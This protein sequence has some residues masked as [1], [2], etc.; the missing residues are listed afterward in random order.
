M[1]LNYACPV[2]RIKLV[3]YDD[4]EGSPTRGTLV[5]AFLGPDNHV[6]AVIPPEVWNGMKGMSAP[7]A[8]V[9]NCATHTHDPSRTEPARP[10]RDR[11][12]V[13]L[14]TH[15]TSR[16][17]C[18]TSVRAASRTCR[19]GQPRALGDVDQRVLA[20]REVQH[21]EQREL[22]HARAAAGADRPVEAAPTELRLALRA[23]VHVGRVRL[24]HVE[25]GQVGVEASAQ[26]PG[27]TKSRSSAEVWYSGSCP[28]PSG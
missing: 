24:E 13:R 3:L 19:V 18:S 15:A 14:V 1:T 2:G 23:Q 22:V 7:F 21:P 6:L 5:E 4:R 12:P 16:R 11:D 9:A 10:A 8:L 25:D 28:G 17:S 26:R 20:V 27:R